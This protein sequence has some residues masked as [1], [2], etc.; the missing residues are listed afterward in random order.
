MDTVASRLNDSIPS[1]LLDCFAYNG[2]VKVLRKSPPKEL[3]Q[4]VLTIQ[5]KSN[6]VEFEKDLTVHLGEDVTTGDVSAYFLEDMRNAI[7][8]AHTELRDGKTN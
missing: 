4:V 1:V 5:Y 6:A 7:I 2:R 3:Y 8:L